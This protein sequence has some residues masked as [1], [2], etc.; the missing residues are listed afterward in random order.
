MLKRSQLFIGILVL[1]AG[2]FGWSFY[3]YCFD[4]TPPVVAIAGIEHEGYYAGDVQCAI[5]MSDNYKVK[6]V[7]VFLD[8]NVLISHFKINRKVDEHVFT[9]PTKTLSNG[10][11][12]LKIE[13]RDASYRKNTTNEVMTF[14]ID[15]RPLQAAFVKSDADIKVFQG[16][17]LHVP[18]Q[19]SK[20]IQEASVKLFNKTFMC[21][22]ESEDSLIYECF[23]PIACEETPNEYLLSF[24]VTDCV[25]NTVTLDTKFQIVPYP[26]KKQNLTI[27]SQKLKE[28]A[29]NGLPA[30]ELNERLVKLFEQSPHKKL[31]RGLFYVP[32]DIKRV[33]TE[34][35]TIR[36]TVHKGRY[37]HNAVDLVGSPHATV[38]APQDGIIV[39]KDRFASS[40]NTVAIDHGCGILSLF[41][42]LDSFANIE[43][44]DKIRKGNPIGKQGKTGHATG[45]HL[46]WETRIN[47]IQVDPMQWVKHDF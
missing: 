34:F 1:V 28:E 22:P 13:V 41:F 26:F 20:P 40:G 17:T 14:Y 21:V 7:S 27:D 37:A 36:T 33:S 44:G 39:L 47:N 10:S 9:I 38:W 35:G 11:H 42:H 12:E 8:G 23:I 29:E 25:G 18:F 45:E 19:V 43:V 2:Y 3:Q 46:H 5:A 16:R 4:T 31:W 32:M 6:D 30:D 15:N 24:E